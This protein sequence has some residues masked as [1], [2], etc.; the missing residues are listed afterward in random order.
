MAESVLKT[1]AAKYDS[2]FGNGHK[3]TK[4][5]NFTR[6]QLDLVY[7]RDWS[8]QKDKTVSLNSLVGRLH[9]SYNAAGVE[10]LLN[11]D[12]WK[13]GTA[14]VVIRKDK[15]FL[16]VS[17]SKNVPKLEAKDAVEIV[18]I[19]VGQNFHFVTYDSSGKSIF[20]SGRKDKNRRGAYK[21]TRRSLQMCQTPSARQTLLQRGS[22][23]SRWMSDVNHCI[24][25]ALVEKYPAGTVFVM[26]DLTGIRKL[27]MVRRHGDDRYELSSWAFHDLREKITYKAAERGQQVIF[28][29]PEYTSQTCPHCGHTEKANRNRKM[30]SFCCKSCGYRSNDDRV[31]A[32][33]LFRIGVAA[34]NGDESMRLHSGTPLMQG[35]Q[36]MILRC[37]ATASDGECGSSSKNAIPQGSHKPSLFMGVGS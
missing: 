17:V 10:H 30:H 23:E 14:K 29:S 5:P 20:V 24:A 19:D 27:E 25:K 37:D 12:V 21:E 4:A 3:L 33:N 28:A 32:M 11:K 16:H 18:G 6:L 31:G 36:S 35:I 34:A 9:M 13:Y 1:V 2:I 26:E 7:G 8:F 22:R 15:C